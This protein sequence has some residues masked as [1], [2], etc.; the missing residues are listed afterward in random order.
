MSK[1]MESKRVEDRL[2]KL[3][4]TLDLNKSL[5]A[6]HEEYKEKASKTIDELR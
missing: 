4:A 3:Q 2:N 1:E 6:E 5:S